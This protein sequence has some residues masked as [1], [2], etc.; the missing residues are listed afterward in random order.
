MSPVSK[1]QCARDKTFQAECKVSQAPAVLRV[2]ERVTE[3]DKF[4]MGACTIKEADLDCGSM[5][6]QQ[7]FGLLIQHA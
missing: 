7:M 5:H 1:K 4:R 2:Y 3:C 6:Q